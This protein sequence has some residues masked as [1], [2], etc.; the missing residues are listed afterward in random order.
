MKKLKSLERLEESF[1]KLPSIGRKSAER[2][3]YSIIEMSDDDVK[4]KMG[5]I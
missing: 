3:A 5:S 1:N 2:L 4:E